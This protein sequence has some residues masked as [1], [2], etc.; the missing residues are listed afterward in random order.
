M[1]TYTLEQVLKTSN[2][3][4]DLLLRQYKL[5]LM[6]GFMEIEANNPRLTQ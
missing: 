1:N 3:E 4:S 6:C 2:L 5:D